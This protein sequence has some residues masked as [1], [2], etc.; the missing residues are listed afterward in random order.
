MALESWTH[1]SAE[2]RK[3][4]FTRGIEGSGPGSCDTFAGRV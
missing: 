4:W 2:Q 1:G 3:A